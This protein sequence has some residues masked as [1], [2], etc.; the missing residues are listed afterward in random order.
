VCHLCLAAAF[1]AFSSLAAQA[2]EITVYAPNIVN[3]P[4]QKL[5][6]AW[7]AETGNKVIFAGFNVGHIRTALGK[8]DPGD[9]LVAPT[10]GLAKGMP[11]NW[12]TPFFA[13]PST[14]P[15]AVTTGAACA[16]TV[17]AQKNARASFFIGACSEYR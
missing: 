9:V 15:S 10:G 16:A 6:D 17:M 14:G 4:L 1:V 12:A 2:A 3:G 13:K 5:A 7:T 8:D 11:R